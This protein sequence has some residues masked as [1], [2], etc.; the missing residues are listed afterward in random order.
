MK[1]GFLDSLRTLSDYMGQC[2]IDWNELD[3]FLDSGIPLLTGDYR[4]VTLDYEFQYST[5]ALFTRNKGST[6][7]PHTVYRTCVVRVVYDSE[8]KR[9]SIVSTSHR[10][11]RHKKIRLGEGPSKRT[12]MRLIKEHSGAMRA[13]TRRYGGSL[14]A[15][16]GEARGDYNEVP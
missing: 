11:N 9:H 15:L 2:D 13:S 16:K 8:S 5:L 12:A 1:T 14:C 7:D 3:S 10:E 4:W 6:R